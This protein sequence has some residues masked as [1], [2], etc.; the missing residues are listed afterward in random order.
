[1]WGMAMHVQSA[2]LLGSVRGWSGGDV[3]FVW[4]RQWTGRRS[5]NM[6]LGGVM[7]DAREFQVKTKELLTEIFHLPDKRPLMD[8]KKTMLMQNDNHSF[9]SEGHIRCTFGSIPHP[10]QSSHQNAAHSAATSA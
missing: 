10:S 2:Y 4:A 9:T 6:G 1:M 3:E 5:R 8:L 7:P